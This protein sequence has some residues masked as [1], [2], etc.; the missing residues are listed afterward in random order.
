MVKRKN[1]N[2]KYHLFHFHLI[3][4]FNYLN[5]LTFITFFINNHFMLHLY[6]YLQYFIHYYLKQT[7]FKIFIKNFNLIIINY[8]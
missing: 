7:C 1:F 4:L 5:Y 3:I 2:F 6:I 8:Y